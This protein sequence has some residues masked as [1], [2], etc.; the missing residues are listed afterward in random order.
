MSKQLPG[1]SGGRHQQQPTTNGP[2]NAVPC[3]H[4]G[5]PNDFRHLSSQQ[6]LDTGAEVSC[7]KCKRLMKV[8]GMQ[9]VQVILVRRVD[10]PAPRQE[11]PARDARTISPGV[12]NRLLGPRR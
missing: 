1:R 3:P 9:T 6:L 10:A 12:L 2:I 4:C 5:A 8:A 7:D 11:A